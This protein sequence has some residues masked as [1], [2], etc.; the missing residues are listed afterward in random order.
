MA[1]EGRFEADLGLNLNLSL[2][3]AGVAKVTNTLKEIAK[4]KDLQ[5]YWKD[6]ETATDNATKAMERYSRNTSSSKLAERFLKEINALKAIS[7]NENLSKLFPKIDLN[8]DELIESAKKIAP[9]INS[10]FSISNFSSAFKTFDLLKEQGLDLTDVFRKL[11][12]YAELVSANI[13]LKR[14]NSSYRELLGNK[15]IQGVQN[16]QN[17]LEKLRMEAEE[18]FES[19]LRVNRISRTDFWGDE[20]FREYF[21]SIKE[22]TMTATEAISTFKAEYSY[23]LEGD[24]TKNGFGLDVLQE[25]STKLTNILR[26]VEDVSTKINDILSNGVITKSMQNLSM[27]STLSDSQRSLFSNLLKDEETLKTITSLFQNLIEESNKTRNTTLFDEEQFNRLLILFEKIESSLSSMKA[28][29]VDVGDGEEFSPLLKMINNV[30]ESIEK[31]STSVK[32]IGLNMNI[33]IGSDKELETQFQDKVSK[34]LIAYQR[35][36]D[37]IKMSGVGG[38]VI[39][40]AFFN[41]DLNH[42][43]TTIGKVKALQ[44]FIDKTRDDAKA[45]YGGQDVLKQDTDAKFWNQASAAL[46]Q[47]KIVEK[48]IKVSTDTSPLE[49]LFGGKTD[50]TEVTTQLGLI[51]TKLE[52]ISA[53]ALEFKNIFKEGFNVT[54][55]I[56][57]IEKLTSRVKE[58]E[59]EL[60]KVKVSSTSPV[61]TNI[62]SENSIADSKKELSNIIDIS[63]KFN[64]SLDTTDKKYEKI[65]NDI[66]TVV[67]LYKKMLSVNDDFDKYNEAYSK[68]YDYVKKIGLEQNVY[69]N[70]IWQGVK[71]GVENDNYD[72]LINGIYSGSIRENNSITEFNKEVIKLDKIL[73]ALYG[74]SI[75]YKEVFLDI[76]NKLRDGAYSY[77]K[78]LN[79]IQEDM[80]NKP[81]DLFNDMLYNEGLYPSQLKD[82]KPSLTIVEG[83]NKI[84]EELDETVAKI[85]NVGKAYD[86]MAYRGIEAEEA[87]AKAS[88][89]YNGATHWS[90]D[91]K[92][93]RGY[94]D[95]VT[96]GNISLKNAF[97]VDGNGAYWD[98]IQILGDG[99]EENSK[100]A[101]EFSTSIDKV[102]SEL[103]TLLTLNSDF[104][105]FNPGFALYSSIGEEISKLSEEQKS[106]DDSESKITSEKIQRLA[107]IRDLYADLV[108]EY[109]KFSIDTSHPYGLKTTDELT[110][111][112]QA[113]GYDGAIY[114]NIID[115]KHS[116]IISGNE[117]IETSNI[118]VSFYE[119]QVEYLEKISRKGQEYIRENISNLNIDSPIEDVFQGDTEAFEMGKVATAVDEAVQAKKDFATANE[120]VQDSV[121]GSKSKLELETELMERLAKSAREAADAKKEFVEAN[122]QIQDSVDDTGKS[123]KK[124]KYKNKSKI[125]EDEYTGKSDY[126]ASIANQKLKNSGTT[127]LGETVS[128]ELVDG[129]VKVTAKIKIVDGAWKTF[130]A[131][132]DADGNMFEQRFRTITKGVD[133][134]ETELKNFGLETNPALSYGETLKKAEEIR[135]SLKLDDSYTI[136][137]DSNELVTITQKLSDVKSS[138]TSVTQTFKSA[139]DAIEHFGKE[140]SSSAEKTTVALKGVKASAESIGESV[141]ESFN[142][143]SIDKSLDKYNDKLRNFTVKPADGYRYPIYQKNIDDLTEKVSKLQTLRD[144]LSKKDINLI[145]KEDIDEV[146]TLEKDIDE[147]IFKMSKMSAS[148][149]GFDPL[150]ADKALEKINSELKKN[151]AMSKEAKRQI[152]GFYDDIRSGNPSKPIKDLLDDMYKLIQAERL[153]GREGKSFMDIFKEKVVYGAAANLA[154]MIG[155]YDIINAG[156]EGITVIRELDTALTEMRKV[157]DESLSSLERFQ[158]ISFDLADD[159]GTTGKQIQDSTA[160]WMRLG[161]AMSEA[162]ESA[163]VS[164][165]LLNVSEFESID[166]ATESLVAMSAAYKD[167]EKIEIVDVLNKIGNEYSISTDGIATALQDS[168]SALVTANNDLNEAVALITAGNAVTQ[169]PNSVGAGMRTISLRLVGTE[170]AKAELE[171]LGEDV[172]DMVMTS[173]KVRETIMNATKAASKDGKGFDILDANGNYKSTYEIMQGLADLY[174]EIVA[175]DKELGTNNLNLLLETIAGK[176]RAN[177]AASI[178]QNGD[179]L[180]SVYKDAQNSDGSAQEELDKY[181]ESIDGKMAKLE[182]QAQEFWYKL[183]DSDTIKNGIT[184]LTE[185][186]G[187]ATDFV[188]TFGALGTAGVGIGAYLGIKNVGI[189]MLVAY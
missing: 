19:F 146:N 39:N 32:G 156:R 105:K 68:T 53:N 33:D 164:N 120:G 2:D 98:K 41:F 23:L 100:K 54:A 155:I 86:I 128:T 132:I 28:V 24:S 36:F 18:I 112:A 181:L 148:E 131:K 14:E 66:L 15:D 31:L 64:K 111:Y 94:G 37:H 70:K 30:Q 186:L 50:L 170:E 161:E 136:K 79:K 163:Q 26:E 22:G 174:D 159:V 137:V 106:Q 166:E 21:S 46:A 160:S 149:K 182:N 4:G 184:L 141:G 168:A 171:K 29:F 20:K 74:K 189:N 145:S 91:E 25:F 44:Q 167:L 95:I 180:R 183:I 10:E 81:S 52:E 122:K 185:L 169:D 119:N 16:Y 103:S 85:N 76:F 90:S 151:S 45:L 154:G 87:V 143:E 177:I 178:L 110:K 127:I 153:A 12:E 43:D 13:D 116:P 75:N 80:N 109:D 34:A 101:I 56:E 57:E 88:K 11:S 38:S 71:T 188:D 140:A 7:G 126:Y 147:L 175:K 97:E 144:N 93:A 142:F 135:N 55:S 83:Q 173:S 123:V 157:S 114:K 69:W 118:I 179:M 17:A 77:D 3:N 176:N 158:G 59:D 125:S 129:L 47:I 65:K 61:E 130:S 6:V 150:G 124:D 162:S 102:Y 115:A 8:I 152:Q 51:V 63:S 108:A 9:T 78:A 62:S 73:Q 133:K 99:L 48:K 139:Q 5:R 1:N 113:N 121:D 96:S 84:Q 89:N 58:L 107:K 60:S 40:D 117:Y 49:N 42:F 172:S 27:D 92:I 187:L 67:D 165:I 72:D 35:L 104:N 134:L 82:N 138:T